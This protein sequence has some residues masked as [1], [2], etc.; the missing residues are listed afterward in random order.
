MKIQIL[1]SGCQKCND[2][3]ANAEKALRQNNLDHELEKITDIEKIVDMGALVTP[4]L[5][6]D[7]KIVSSGKILSLD[8]ILQLLAAQNADAACCCADPEEAEACCCCCTGKQ[9]NFFKKVLTVLLLIIVIGSSLYLID[10][11][12]KPAGKSSVR[13]LPADVLKVYYFHGNQRCMTCNKIEDLTRKAVGKSEKCRFIPVNVEET[14]NE[15]FIKDFQLGNRCVVMERN[16]K[17][18]KFERVWELV[19]DPEKFHS[20]LTEGMERLSK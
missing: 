12:S 4:A 6:I 2:L 16:G 10:K 17:F 7:G 3:F 8:E 15:H 11:D 19:S 1:G 14:Q 13:S 9:N 18:E 5:A 20:Y